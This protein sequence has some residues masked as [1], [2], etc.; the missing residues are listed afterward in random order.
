MLMIRH[1][2]SL[3]NIDHVVAGERECRGLTARGRRQAHAVA[4]RLSCEQAGEISAVYA[5]PVPR[6]VQTATPI[7][8]AVGA[9]VRLE[10][11]A[12]DYGA[13]EGQTWTYVLAR[14]DPPLALTPDAPMAA[15]AESWTSWVRRVGA[16]IDLLAERHHGET[17]ILVCHRESILAAEQYLNRG[18]VT[19]AYA[20]AEVD[21]AS[22]TEWQH[23]RLGRRWWRWAR[24]RHNDVT[25]MVLDTADAVSL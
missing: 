3:A 24:V 10:L 17:I 4:V 16:S 11:P 2:E 21:H 22:I 20:T 23:R 5:T 14:H 12:P 6:T 9:P 15:G 1:G 18:P 7:A 19:L 13:A 8:E 25:H